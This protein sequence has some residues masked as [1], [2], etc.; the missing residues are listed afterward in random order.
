M[1]S[2]RISI[3]ALVLAAACGGGGSN[4]A[5]DAAVG[6]GAA[7]DAAD[8][9]TTCT[10][11]CRTTALTAAFV[12]NRPL[13]RAVYGVTMTPPSLHVEAYA[14][15]APGCPTQ[16]S[17]SP[18]YTFILGRVPVPMSTAPSTPPGP[19]N[20]LDFTGDLLGGP[21]GAAATTVAITPVAAADPTGAAGFV[22]LDVTATFANGTV[23]GHVF[24][25]H[26][27]SLDAAN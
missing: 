9:F 13:D 18:D 23:T 14:G 6:D 7:A 10:G 1:T 15:A 16:S 19:G 21:L 2:R 26:C 27:A 22:A 3:V 25:D 17:P 4:P 12:V 11:A 24:A 5:V 20:I 8:G